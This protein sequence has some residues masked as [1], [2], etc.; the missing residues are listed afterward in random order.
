M[1]KSVAKTL[2][3]I[4]LISF[5][6]TFV[7]AHKSP[8]YF[9]LAQLQPIA[10]FSDACTQAYNAPLAPCTA[11]DFYEGSSCS[12]ECV[13]YLEAMTALL[14]TV[15]RGT[16]AFPNTLIGM[17]FERVAV[18][19]LCSTIMAPT[20]PIESAGQDPENPP[21]DQPAA[22]SQSIEPSMSNSAIPG[23]PQS[24]AQ[25]DAESTS[26][27]TKVTTTT[28]SSTTSISSSSSSTA[29][30]TSTISLDQSSVGPASSGASSVVVAGG[31][32]PS[33]TKIAAPPESTSASSDES[34]EEGQSDEEGGG[35]NNG[36]G[37]TVLDAASIAGSGVTCT[38]GLLLSMTA[39][40][41]AA[42]LMS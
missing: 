35:N 33:S 11:S 1:T 5:A 9:S 25:S 27:S 41:A 24:T 19:K 20:V 39:C 15:C 18:G 37:G 22:T 32:V 34:E 7:S 10:G 31:D 4:L 8:S 21:P 2:R 23:I 38:P 12:V 42:V 17:F 13:A 14:N 29:T 3:S 30:S 28:A 40:L 26:T 6:G 36:D 16:I